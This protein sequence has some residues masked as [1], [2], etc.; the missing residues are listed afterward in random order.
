M[1]T[2][3]SH[4]TG[5][6]LPQLT[7]NKVKQQSLVNQGTSMVSS[8]Y[9][10]LS[11]AER[12]THRGALLAKPTFGLLFRAAPPSGDSHSAH[13]IY[14][15]HLLPLGSSNKPLFWQFPVEKK[16]CSWPKWL[17]GRGLRRPPPTSS[18][19]SVELLCIAISNT[20]ENKRCFT[21]QHRLPTLSATCTK[22]AAATSA[23]GWS[24]ICH[25]QVKQKRSEER[26]GPAA[27]PMSSSSGKCT[28]CWQHKC[29]HAEPQA[30]VPGTL[31]KLWVA[32]VFFFFFFFHGVIW[33]KLVFESL[34]NMRN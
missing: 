4:L 22:V 3:R 29:G 24:D 34:A 1:H 18:L 25:K 28:V 9:L 6:G 8:V 19:P 12:G 17:K 31:R 27:G 7:V 2:G 5:T 33:R 21:V 30:Q 11:L 13:C 20:K 14:T 32:A 26:Q 10:E 15:P 23:C 16:M